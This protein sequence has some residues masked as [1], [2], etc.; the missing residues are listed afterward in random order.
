M[1]KLCLAFIVFSLMIAG[2]AGFTETMFAHYPLDNAYIGYVAGKN[3]A[4]NICLA[5]KSFE[6]NEVSDLNYYL[7]KILD[8][9]VFDEE[10]Y[11]KRYKE[12]IDMDKGVS[13]NA[14]Y[15][16]CKNFRSMI[17]EYTRHYGKNYYHISQSIRRG[18][19]EEINAMA[20]SLS[21]F[22][23]TLSNTAQQMQYNI[24]I[25]EVNFKPENK[26]QVDHYLVNTSSGLRQCRVTSKGY[27][28]CF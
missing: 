5:N 14:R 10:L 18:R 2:C 16:M 8:I 28:F 13:E 22:G 21:S 1:K 7:A 24:K 4:I 15:E 19:Q 23:N 11:K 26:N 3:A 17:P 12:L 20:N 27:I 6:Y 25:P 9:S